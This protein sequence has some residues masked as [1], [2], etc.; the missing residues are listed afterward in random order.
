[1]TF[2]LCGAARM[3]WVIEYAFSACWKQQKQEKTPG[4]VSY[5][6]RQKK[7]FASGIRNLFSFARIRFIVLFRSRFAKNNNSFSI[8]CNIL[9]VP[10]LILPTHDGIVDAKS[11]CMLEK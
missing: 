5:P 11:V 4:E 9:Y 6:K 8:G 7:F 1:M 2:S 10:K 3:F